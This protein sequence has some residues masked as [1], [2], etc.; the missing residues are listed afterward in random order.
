MFFGPF[1]VTVLILSM[2]N[3]AKA[4]KTQ[5]VTTL[6]ENKF[7]GPN[8]KLQ[9]RLFGH[10]AVDIS[11]LIK[12]QMAA[13]PV[14]DGLLRVCL[15]RSEHSL[16]LG[17]R[18][19]SARGNDAALRSVPHQCYISPR[20]SPSRQL[21]SRYRTSVDWHTFVQEKKQSPGCWVEDLYYRCKL[22]A[23]TELLRSSSSV[24]TGR[25]VHLYLNCRLHKGLF[26]LLRAIIQKAK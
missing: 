6:K 17:V 20:S 15:Q 22:T 3:A 4:Y 25:T 11:K 16:W 1:E 24:K 14:K 5:N 13:L 10:A 9:I 26:V 2:F 19:G 18:G 21:V 7:W 8:S 12:R 23:W